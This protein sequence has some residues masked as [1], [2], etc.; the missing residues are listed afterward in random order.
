MD[1]LN[2]NPMI[3][4]IRG[5]TNIAPIITAVEFTFNPREAINMAKTNIQRLVPLNSIP[6]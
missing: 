3:G 1:I 5:E 4:P 6:F 2:P